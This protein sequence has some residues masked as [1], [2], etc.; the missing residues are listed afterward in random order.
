[1]ESRKTFYHLRDPARGNPHQVYGRPSWEIRFGTASW[2]EKS[3]GFSTGRL[4]P[5]YGEPRKD[6]TIILPSARVGDFVWTFYNDCIVTDRAL[7]LFKQ[8]GFTGFEIRP[9]IVEKIERLSR[10]RRDQ[11]IV[12]LLWELPIIGK[13]GDAA[14]ESGIYPLYEIEDGYMKRFQYSSFRNGIIVDEANWDGSDFFT[15]NGYPKF[16][17]VT[18][19]VK[20]LI[21]K[22]QLTNCALIPSHELRWGPGI[23][24]EES[25][26]ET[27]ELAARP[28]ESLLADLENPESQRDAIYGLGC[29]GDPRAVDPLISKFDDPDPFVWSSAAGSVAAIARRTENPEEVREDIF[30]RLCAM[31]G[32]NDSQIRQ[33]AV[34]AL[35][36]IGSD[37]AAEQVMKLLDDPDEWVRDGAV[38]VVGFLRYR[39]ALEPLRR[40][41][42]D[43][44]KQVRKK[45]RMMVDRLECDFP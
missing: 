23:T 7:A 35:G 39:P 19:R 43:R 1:M 13:G 11:V 12:P 41:T 45:A 10:K 2:S 5:P 8:A 33:S 9:V 31:L 29:K 37:G 15:I 44:S 32:H 21:I 3:A 26:A 34:A 27:L 38:F 36:Y 42:K 4:V 14:P 22:L 25:H 24:P 18:E 20:E 28:L 17:L 16:I 40:L 30:S 6:L